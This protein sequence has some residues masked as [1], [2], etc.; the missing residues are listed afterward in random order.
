MNYNF[1]KNLKIKRYYNEPNKSYN[2]VSTVIFRLENNY[3]DMSEYYNKFKHYIKQFKNIFDDS[4]Y[5]RIYFDNSIVLYGDNEIIN[6]EITTIW[7]PLL[8]YLYEL[9]FVQLCKYNHN[10]FKKNKIYHIGVFGTIIRFLPLFD[11]SFNKNINVI[12]ITDID[13]NQKYIKYI[14]KSLEYTLK[15]NLNFFFRT[16]FCKYTSGYHQTSSNIVNTWLRIMAGTMISNNL[17]F[18]KKII[19]DFFGQIINNNYDEHLNKFINM[20]LFSIHKH[21]VLSEPI[22]KYGIDEFFAMYLLK[23]LIDNNNKIK[24]GYLAANDIDSPIYFWYRKNNKL[25]DNKP[26]YKEILQSLLEIGRAHV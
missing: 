18:P 22:F 4:Y 6:N 2:I 19:N 3:K 17:K 12:L 21:K 14:V 16:S 20:D 26:V 13:V 15:N 11:Y 1:I 25:E 8:K 5:L 24:F 23:F 7:R 9:P 10:E